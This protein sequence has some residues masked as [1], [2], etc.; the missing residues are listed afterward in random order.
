MARQ[1]PVPRLEVTKI[2][3]RCRQIRPQKRSMK[4]LPT[5]STLGWFS[6]KG[7]KRMRSSLPSSLFHEAIQKG[8][9]ATRLGL[10]VSIDRNNDRLSEYDLQ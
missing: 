3:V 5:P 2:Q 7:P 9:S 8:I 10:G 6:W 1:R 4:S